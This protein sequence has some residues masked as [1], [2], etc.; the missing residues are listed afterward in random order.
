M[1]GTGMTGIAVRRPG[2]D[3]V[4]DDSDGDGKDNDVD[5]DEVNNHADDDVADADGK[6]HLEH[7]NLFR[8]ICEKPG[9]TIEA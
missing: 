4:A 6:T 8:F 1:S 5:D 9:A 2:N 3:D 7:N